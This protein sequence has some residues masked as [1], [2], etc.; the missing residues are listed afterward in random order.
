[1]GNKGSDIN[2]LADNGVAVRTDSEKAYHMHNKFVVVDDTFL[3]TG[4]FNW[5]V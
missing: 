3:I 1:M 4:S 5:T 2:Y